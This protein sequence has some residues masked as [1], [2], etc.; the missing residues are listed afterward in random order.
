MTYRA[1]CAAVCVAAA[2][3]SCAT[4]KWGYF[5]TNMSMED[6]NFPQMLSVVTD[7][8]PV[9]GNHVE[10]LL[11]GDRIFPAMLRDIE[12]AAKSI[13]VETYIFTSDDVGRRV[14]SALMGKAREGVAVRVLVD[15]FGNGLDDPLAEAMRNAGV[16]LVV[17]KPFDWRHPS[18][19]TGAPIVKSWSWTA[20]S[21]TP[22]GWAL[23][24][25]GRA[26]PTR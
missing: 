3:V 6:P 4:V 19:A 17:F 26:T 24:T 2:A 21:G 5:R 14:A 9:G 12:S 15:D 16:D 7:D 18:T 10:I 8:P 11:N 22:A 23:T 25:A 13:H 1:R 20:A